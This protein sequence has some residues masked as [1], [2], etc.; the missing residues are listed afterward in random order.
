MK[1]CYHRHPEEQTLCSASALDKAPL[2]NL[3]MQNKNKTENCL[4]LWTQTFKTAVIRGSCVLV[5]VLMMASR[6][7]LSMIHLYLLMPE[8][9]G[10]SNTYCSRFFITAAKCVSKRCRV[11]VEQPKHC[12][13]MHFAPAVA[14][15]KCCFSFWS[16]ASS[17]GFLPLGHFRNPS[18]P[19]QAAFGPSSWSVLNGCTEQQFWR[20][21]STCVWR[22]VS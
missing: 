16:S 15:R 17:S 18:R 13:L 3:H 10:H 9:S 7:L 5:D 22:T 21:A 8:G 19:A 14:L 2:I 1:I 4:T 11:T 6:F 12:W 20:T